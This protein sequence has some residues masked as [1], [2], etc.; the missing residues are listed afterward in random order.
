MMADSHT[1]PVWHRS[2]FA[3]VSL[4]LT[5]WAS[6]GTADTGNSIFL[7][8]DAMRADVAACMASPDFQNNPEACTRISFDTCMSDWDQPDD[9][10]KQSNCNHHAFL[11]WRDVYQDELLELL[12]RATVRDRSAA[13]DREP[14]ISAFELVMTRSVAWRQFRE[15]ECR[16]EQSEYGQSSAAGTAYSICL[17]RETSKRINILRSRR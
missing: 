8:Y 1:Q 5:T 9:R 4:F 13:A 17:S 11:I 3:F 6:L 12:Q 14:D 2:V 7:P 15:E 10:V 16:F